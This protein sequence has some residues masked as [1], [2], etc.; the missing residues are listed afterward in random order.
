MVDTKNRRSK[1]PD[2][3][4]PSKHANNI[5]V[6]FPNQGNDTLTNNVVDCQESLCENNLGSHITEHCQ[7]SNELQVWTQII[8]QKINERIGGIRE[9]IQDKFE[10]IH[11]EI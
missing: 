5:E 10:A 1:R 8:Q 4:P 11:L 9:E 6:E 2:S 3:P 7:I